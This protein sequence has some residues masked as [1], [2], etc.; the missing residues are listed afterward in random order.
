V[1]GW[2]AAGTVIGLAIAVGTFFMGRNTQRR[3]GQ[4]LGVETL[5]TDTIKALCA[6]AAGAAGAGAF[7]QPV[8]VSGTAESGPDGP[9][10]SELSKTPCVWQRHQ[11][12]RR[13]RHYETDSKGN[14][15]ATTREEVVVENTSEDPFLLRDGVGTIPVIPTRVIDGAKKSVSEFR[16]PTTHDDGATV[17]FGPI[18][19]DLG[20]GDNTL[21][22][23]YEEWIL[24][25]GTKV[26][27]HGE[28]TD[29]GGELVIA[30]PAGKAK[31]VIS[32]KSETQL[33]D[34]AEKEA[35]GLRIAT[36]VG[37]GIAVVCIVSSF[38]F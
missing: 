29:A 27:V 25:P 32:T 4:L 35:T 8:E 37:L 31:L 6:A 36:L 26:F 1:T 2:W 5:T 16:E 12:T 11:V 17:S 13:Y 20:G 28:A 15:T 21:G 18:E 24:K 23:E 3:R 22:Y 38:I 33:L 7:R 19:I 9:L 10:T 34:A 14:R 30:E